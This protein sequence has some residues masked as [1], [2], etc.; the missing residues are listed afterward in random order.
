MIGANDNGAGI[1][2]DNGSLTVS[3]QTLTEGQARRFRQAVQAE[4][5]PDLRQRR[6]GREAMLRLEEEIAAAQQAIRVANDIAETVGLEALRGSQI[7]TSDRKEHEGRKRIASRDGLETLMTT[8]SLSP[9]QYAAG[10]RFRTDYEL[11]DPEK[12]LT[13]PAIDQSRN[14]TRGGEGWAAK[15]TERELF[16]RDLEKLIQE[17]DRT[18]KGANGR[19]AVQRTGRAVWALREIAGKGSNLRSLSNSGSVQA[20]ISAALVLALDCAAVAYGLE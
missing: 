9:N 15:R 12:G 5:S 1:A 7:E 8:R 16:V 6:E 10:L 4:A 2:N 14:I 18:F 3:G 11:L 20:S 17:E 19:T 13:P